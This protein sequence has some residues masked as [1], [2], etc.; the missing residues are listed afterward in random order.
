MSFGFT[1]KVS[2]ISNAIFDAARYRNERILFFAVAANDGANH[3]VMFPANHELVISIRATDGDGVFATLNP[4]TT[5][6]EGIVY[7]TLGM[8]VPGVALNGDQG[9]IVAF[10]SGCSVATAIAAGTAALL[11]G[12][13]NMMSGEERFQEVHDELRTR[14]GMLAMFKEISTRSM[15]TQFFYLAPFSDRFR[16]VPNDLCWARVMSTVLNT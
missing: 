10:K 15:V 6:E 5:D 16:G 7:G 11:L 3:K 2:V 4:P 1:S 14:R 9:E 12:Y 13:V 8:D